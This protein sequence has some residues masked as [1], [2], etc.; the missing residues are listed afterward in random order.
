M[1]VL[2]RRPR[3]LVVAAELVLLGAMLGAWVAA[4]MATTNDYDQLS[5]A[6]RSIVLAIYATQDSFTLALILGLVAIA[7]L[8]LRHRSPLA[9][10]FLVIGTVSVLH[11]RYPVFAA[12]SFVSE[13][14]V[15]IVIFWV[16]WKT[17][18]WWLAVIGG[19]VAAIIT[20]IPIFEINDNL[21]QSD[22][23]TSG[24][25]LSISTMIG[26]IVMVLLGLL[27][28]V[29]ARRLGLQSAELEQRNEQLA[30]QRAKAEQAA[31][32]DERVR[33]ARELHDV[34]AHHV[35]TM[36]VHAGATRHVVGSDAPMVEGALRQIEESGREAIDELQ[37]V[38]GFL[39]GEDHDGG[40][41][42][43]PSLRRL[44]ELTES[45]N[46]SLNVRIVTEG[47]L[48]RIPSAVDMSGYRIVQEALT[49]TIKHSKATQAHV[50]LAAG[51]KK[52]HIEVTDKGPGANSMA[53]TGHGLVGIRERANLHGGT[54]QIGP[55][56]GNGWQVVATLPY[57]GTSQ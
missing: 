5:P 1:R 12:N 39:R 52:L 36:T 55:R 7:A 56:A 34:V 24:R 40:R 25:L 6:I 37:R 54:V 18:F 22:L 15:L 33:I 21:Q 11:F 43:A 57:E 26:S 47:D 32:L 53:G 38:L 8:L 49:N 3:L 20:A 44:S 14:C 23:T 10:F 31:V 51:P 28:G 30:L 29:G 4:W 13:L 27:G 17:R 48:E 9:A 46:G 16:A 41:A 2:S 50:R 19:L 45:L 35:T 42:P